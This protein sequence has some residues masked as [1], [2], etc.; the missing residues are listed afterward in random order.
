MLGNLHPKS[1]SGREREREKGW[2]KREGRTGQ[3]RLFTPENGDKRFELRGEVHVHLRAPTTFECHEP[4]KP[5]RLGSDVVILSGEILFGEFSEE[6]CEWGFLR[7]G[8]LREGKV[9][10]GREKGTYVRRS[11]GGSDATRAAADSTRARLRQKWRGLKN[12]VSSIP[13]KKE[14]QAGRRAEGW[15]EGTYSCPRERR[16]SPPSADHEE[17]QRAP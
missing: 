8:L 11:G 9:G 7:S 3:A 4:D 5:A 15:K 13:S 17:A 1:K 16:A 2:R 6:D 10:G 12:P 14:G